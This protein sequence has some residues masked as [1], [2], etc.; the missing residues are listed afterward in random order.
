[1]NDVMK[2]K[3]GK[4][5]E[6]MRAFY[7]EASRSMEREKII[8]ATEQDYHIRFSPAMRFIVLWL[9]DAIH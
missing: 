2:S 8:D 6:C 9:K 3:N 7:I 5:K 4:E 1:M